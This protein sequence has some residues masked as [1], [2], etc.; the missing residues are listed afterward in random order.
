MHK[1]ISLGTWDR[2]MDRG[3][4]GSWHCL[5][6]PTPLVARGIIQMMHDVHC[7]PF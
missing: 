2:Q 4:D 6:L 7:A 1:Y 3:M 5:T